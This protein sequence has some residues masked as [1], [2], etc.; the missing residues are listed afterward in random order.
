LN[1]QIANTRNALNQA[2]GQ[3]STEQ[4]TD[5]NPL[6]SVLQT[7]LVREQ[8]REAGLKVRRDSLAA[9]YSSNR[10]VLAQVEGQTQEYDSLKRT[11][12]ESE[13]DY[14]LY[15]RKQEEARIADSL[16]QQK[17]ANV[18]VAEAPVEH[19]IP[20]KPRVGMSLL[21]GAMLAGLVGL[22]T[23]LG[24]ESSRGRMHSPA[25]IESATGIPVLAAIAMKRL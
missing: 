7:D 25:E 6:H 12:K 17:M 24:L 21:V 16:D 1:D 9:T 13:E 2:V 20:T 5:V 4:V 23:G 15:S 18:A 3:I 11:V 14:I 8:L 19:Y 22:S 10:A